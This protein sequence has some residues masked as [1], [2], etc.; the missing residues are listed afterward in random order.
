MTDIGQDDAGAHSPQGRYEEQSRALSRMDSQSRLQALLTGLS[1]VYGHGDGCALAAELLV[2]W[3]PSCDDTWSCREEL[4]DTVTMLREGVGRP[5]VGEPDCIWFD[6]LP[7]RLTV[8]RGAAADR[9]NGP[10]WTTDRTVALDFAC[11]HRGERLP[12]PVIVSGCIPKD[13]ILF[14][15]N[16][17]EESEVLLDWRDV[18]QMRIRGVE[19]EVTMLALKRAKGTLSE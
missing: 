1:A 6:A 17:R 12:D 5:I 16:D 18:R 15:T 13:A 11:G 8:Y 9:W 14:A 2:D 10:S 19:G 7:Q 3:W 4:L